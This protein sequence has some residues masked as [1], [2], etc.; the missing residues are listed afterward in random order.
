[1][2]VCVCEG[3]GEVVLYWTVVDHALDFFVIDCSQRV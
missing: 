1:M 2:F 3:E